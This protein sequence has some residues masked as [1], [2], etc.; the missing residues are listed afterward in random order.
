MTQ[1]TIDWDAVDDEVDV[2]PRKKFEFSTYQKAVFEDTVSGT[3][4]TVIAALAG[5]AKTTTIVEALNYV[6]KGKDT[7]FCAFNK[8]IVEELK[9]RDIPYDAT[10]LTLHQHGFQAVRDS[11]GKQKVEFNRVGGILGKIFQGRSSNTFELRTRLTKAVSLCKSALASED[12]AIDEVMDRFTI[13]PAGA[14]LNGDESMDRE[15]FINY[16]KQVLEICR[17]VKG[18]VDFDDMIWLPIINKLP[19]N[20][21]DRVFIDETQDLSP[22][23]I[24]LA[25]KSVKK[26]GRITAV[27]DRNQ[28]IYQWRGASL[29]ALDDIIN[30]FDARVLPLPICY[31]CPVSVIQ[32]AQEIVPEIQSAPGAEQGRVIEIEEIDM[33]KNAKAGDAVLSR[34]NAPLLGICF[35]FLAD[36]RK[37]MILGKDIGTSLAAFIR[38]S[39][40]GTIQQLMTYTDDWRARECARLLERSEPRKMEAESVNDKA[41]CINV[42][43]RNAGSVQEVLA[44]I[45]NLF[46]DT[47]ESNAITLSSIHKFKGLERDNVYLIMRSFR[48]PRTRWTSEA[49]DQKSREE[50]NIAY[51]GVTRAKKDLYLVTD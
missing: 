21:Y 8:R 9:K 43:S 17:D 25:L 41:N 46:S 6:P 20:R 1:E 2:Q 16:V 15:C 30:R 28:A 33:L 11:Y 39:G 32:V 34:L 7:L 35:N 51:V 14:C 50:L 49:I 37:A 31:R 19:I 42:L 48:I 3:N 47:N 29:N 22:A 44:S 26:S 38:K 45:E 12:Q 36:G 40:C 23:Q 24:E 10:V 4:H 27:G 5:A 18:Q 13:D